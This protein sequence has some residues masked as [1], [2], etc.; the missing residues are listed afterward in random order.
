MTWY[1]CSD[2]EGLPQVEQGK[3]VELLIKPEDL[4]FMYLST[5][6]DGTNLWVYSGN[7]NEPWQTLDSTVHFKSWSYR[8]WMPLSDN[9][10]FFSLC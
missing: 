8:R 1:N 10:S 2:K 5:V 9:E 6:W 4:P 7:Q 3:D